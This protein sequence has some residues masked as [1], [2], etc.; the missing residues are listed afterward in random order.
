MS[1]HSLLLDNPCPR[2]R[3][4]ADAV[5]EIMDELSLIEITNT[6]NMALIAVH[7]P[8]SLTYQINSRH[9]YYLIRDCIQKFNYPH[10]T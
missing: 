10:L 7:L 2:V 3:P 1:I 4:S 9:F 5:I 8:R 6:F